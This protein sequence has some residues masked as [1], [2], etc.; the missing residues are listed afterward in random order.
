MKPRAWRV[1]YTY[2]N[3]PTEYAARI[4]AADATDAERVFRRCLIDP[5]TWDVVITRIVEVKEPCL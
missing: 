4:A 5:D 3:D 1:Y 2:P